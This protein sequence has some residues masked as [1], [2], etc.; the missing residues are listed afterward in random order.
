MTT[1]LLDLFID[2][3]YYHLKENEEIFEKRVEYINSIIN[4]MIN[5]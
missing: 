2:K 5:F 1:T 4:I 3:L